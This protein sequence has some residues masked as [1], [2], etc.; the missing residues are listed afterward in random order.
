MKVSATNDLCKGNI[1]RGKYV[2]TAVAN[3]PM[4]TENGIDKRICNSVPGMKVST[5]PCS[6]DNIMEKNDGTVLPNDL[7]Q[8]NI[9]SVPGLK[10]S[11]TYGNCDGGNP[12]G[13]YDGTVLTN[14]PLLVE[15]TSVPGLKV[16]TIFGICD[17]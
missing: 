3:N 15:I 10:V 7:L 6:G 8:V 12:V 16:S 11:T 4:I 13:K 14:D 2:G 17:G 1:S 9:T 5:N